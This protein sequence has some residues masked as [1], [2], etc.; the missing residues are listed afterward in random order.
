MAAPGAGIGPPRAVGYFGAVWG[1]L[2]GFPFY[3]DV[4]GNA[5]EWATAIGTGGAAIA[6]ATYYILSAR[7]RK[8]AQARQVHAAVTFPETGKVH[9][10]NFVLYNRNG[11]HR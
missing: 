11:F 9:P 7:S 5:A 10:F 2:W 1:E 8:R 6:A 4:W 3:A